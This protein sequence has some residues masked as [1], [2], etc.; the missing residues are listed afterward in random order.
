MKKT[1]RLIS[2]IGLFVLAFAVFPVSSEPLKIGVAPTNGE[3]SVTLAKLWIPFLEKLETKSGIQLRFATAPDLLE[4]NQRL[5]RGEYDL[6]IT[7]QY[8]FT[9]FR[10]KHQLSYL[11]EL[12]TEGE[13]P[14]MGLVTASDIV[15]VKQLEGSLL[16]VKEDES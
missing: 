7:D 1:L 9:I 2:F 13:S 5:A 12:S 3:D 16:A 14:E 15:N 8:L 4:F 6:V 11:A 10:Q